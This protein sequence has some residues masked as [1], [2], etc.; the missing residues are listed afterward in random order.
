MDALALCAKAALAVMLIIA[1]GAKFADRVGFAAVVRLFIPVR[2]L[3]PAYK[4]IGTAIAFAEVI[5]GCASLSF[6]AVRWIN[7]IIL[8]AGCAFVIV[9]VTGFVFHRGKSCSCFGALSRRKFDVQSIFRNMLIAAFAAVAMVGVSPSSIRLG[10]T[11]QA[12]LLVAGATVLAVSYT[13]AKAL[14]VVPE[15]QPRVGAR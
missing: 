4:R 2:A 10:V 12:L 8:I 11:T 3:A 6:P 5:L 15:A 13:A 7:L 14:A 1:G 9:S